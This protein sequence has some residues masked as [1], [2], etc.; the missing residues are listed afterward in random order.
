MAAG[1]TGEVHHGVKG[2]AVVA[3]WLGVPGIALTIHLDRHHAGLRYAI[4]NVIGEKDC[5][6][7][8]IQGDG[9]VSDSFSKKEI[10]TVPF[11]QNAIVR[12]IEEE[13]A[14]ELQKAF[15]VR[16][17]SGRVLIVRRDRETAEKDGGASIR[18]TFYRGTG[19]GYFDVYRSNYE[20]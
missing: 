4:H 8:L 19:D 5:T 7:S 6:I 12:A 18:E 1:I 17:A 3:T 2:V 16:D 10:A 15:E 20:L 9:R 13:R 14:R 11:D